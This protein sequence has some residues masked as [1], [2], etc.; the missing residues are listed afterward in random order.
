MQYNP[1]YDTYKAYMI[2]ILNISAYIVDI[3]FVI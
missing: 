2:H 3:K 1:Y